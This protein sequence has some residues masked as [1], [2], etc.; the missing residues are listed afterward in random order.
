MK[1]LGWERLDVILV[2]GDAYV[3]SSYCGVAVIGRVLAA[4]GLRVGVIAQPAVDRGDDI[5]RLG[6]PELFW[7]VSAGAVDSMV[8]NYTPLMKPRREDDLTPGGVNNRRPDR[9]SIVYANLI[10]RAFRRPAPIVLGGIEASLR[11]IA[12]YDY[13]SDSIRRP[14]LF[15]AKA[16]Y[17]LYG[18]AEN[19]VVELA[20]ALRAGQSPDGIRGLC[21]IAREKHTGYVELPDYEG[22]AGDKAAFAHMFTLFSRNM[23]PATANGL[24]QRC[25]DRWLIHNPPPPPLT[26]EELARVY[27]LDY[28][29]AVHPHCAAL[30]GVRALDTIR[31]SITS[32]RGCYGECNFCAIAA[33]QGRR[34]VSRPEA[35]IVQE[36]QAVARHPGFRGIIHDVGGPTANMYGI[37]C[38]RK[39]RGACAGKRC[40]F[41]GVC[42]GLA[43]DHGRQIELLRRL[44]AVPGVKKVFIG[45]G[46]R[47]DLVVADSANGGRYLDELVQHH[48]S[49]QLKLAP[50]HCEAEVLR[51]MGKPSIRVLRRFREM[52]RL[53]CERRGKHCFLT[54]YFIAA[55]PGCTEA[56][57]RALACFAHTEL[58]HRPEQVQIFTPT[59]S[60]LG[61]LMY[62]TGRDPETGQPLFVE[63][64]LAGKR[65]QKDLVKG[66]A[67]P[68]GRHPPRPL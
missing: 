33:H 56:H 3:D 25:G 20:E 4:A 38:N 37:E 27:G 12:H 50:E 60:T 39:A 22:V 29:R 7:G 24:V 63:K 49:G 8:S 52:F 68:A 32:H 58:H 53:A 46:V 9:A 48:I 23:D 67:V 21:R 28:E 1:G 44:R 66:G 64:T 26:P 10:R 13:W 55:Y 34:V 36:A 61:A 43:V 19:S 14:L 17:L 15:D 35:S 11:R 57:M 62:W 40:I 59:P 41:P 51:R 30:G 5:A 47:Y 42:G 31:W 2:S 65:R 16:D 18:M 54:Y 6:A 45:S